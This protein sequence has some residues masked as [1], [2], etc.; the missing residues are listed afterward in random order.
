MDNVKRPS[1]NDVWIRVR[2]EGIYNGKEFTYTDPIGE[3]GS[4]TVRE[5][6]DGPDPSTYWWT[7]GNFSCDCNRWK[8]L[9]I[10]LQKE[11]G[12]RLDEC[13]NE[14]KFRTLT[15]IDPPYEGL[16]INFDES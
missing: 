14:I 6:E 3:D 4:T 1:T 10:E 16:Q 7:E 8:F 11:R 15:V 2:I 13:G 5:G 12:D 9:P